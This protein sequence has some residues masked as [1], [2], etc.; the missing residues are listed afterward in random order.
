MPLIAW[1]EHCPATFDYPLA[2]YGIA[3]PPRTIYTPPDGRG[4][5]MRW[6]FLILI[7]LFPQ[8]SLASDPPIPT[9][10]RLPV[11][12]PTADDVNY[13]VLDEGYPFKWC[14][15]R[16]PTG[17]VFMGYAPAT[18]TCMDAMTET[19][20][21]YMI[22][23]VRVLRYIPN[24]SNV[25]D[26]CLSESQGAS[27]ITS[28]LNPV[29][30]G[31]FGSYTDT[32]SEDW[33]GK[34]YSKPHYCQKKARSFIKYN[35]LAAAMAPE[36]DLVLPWLNLR[37]D[38]SSKKM[39]DTNLNAP[40][41]YDLTPDKWYRNIGIIDYRTKFSPLSASQLFLLHETHKCHAQGSLAKCGG[42]TPECSAGQA[43]IAFEQSALNEIQHHRFVLKR[44]ALSSFASA[45]PRWS[46]SEVCTLAKL[47]DYDHMRWMTGVEN[48][49]WA[50]S[51]K[52][53]NDHQND[54]LCLYLR[55]ERLK[56]RRT[57]CGDANTNKCPVET[58]SQL[59]ARSNQILSRTP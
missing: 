23:L 32:W 3:Q 19:D 58:C 1:H 25:T 11:I 7:L 20:L 30:E 48:G 16:E 42:P 10:F 27:A 26:F 6:L 39:I 22:L 49:F 57:D 12:R 41:V 24:N 15:I 44:F 34:D 21:N 14:A 46:P 59:I 33:S 40:E 45:D 29:Y 54:H 35:P 36:I 38:P 51:R 9:N 56:I 37:F 5:P 55:D 18:Q 50:V 4:A 17:G 53:E 31:I 52:A 8:T 47:E 28:L 2:I 13:A 43:H